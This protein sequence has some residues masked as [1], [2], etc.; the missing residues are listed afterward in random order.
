MVNPR[1]IAGERKKKKKKKKKK[2]NSSTRNSSNSGKNSSSRTI[3]T[4][5]KRKR[6]MTEI[7][8]VVI[9]YDFF[10]KVFSLNCFL[11][12]RFLSTCSLFVC[13]VLNVPATC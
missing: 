11:R 3:T 4:L 13:R 7:M 8:R 1:D 5:I 2:K 12:T 10:T 9:V 6:T